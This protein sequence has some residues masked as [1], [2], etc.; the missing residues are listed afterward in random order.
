MLTFDFVF[1][2]FLITA[3]AVWLVLLPF[4]RHG[5]LNTP[6]N[7]ALFWIGIVATF[8]PNLISWWRTRSANA[9]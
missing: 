4:Q 1:N 2:I 5:T 6:H 9:R 7:D 8:L 3:S